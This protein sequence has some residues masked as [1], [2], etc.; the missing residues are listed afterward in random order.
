[1]EGVNQAE[2]KFGWLRAL[3]WPIH[4]HEMKKLVPMLL[5][6]FFITFNYNVL[7]T[8]KDTL[9]VNAKQS[10]A[11]VIPF[12]KFWFMFPGS[13]LMAYLY[14]RLSNRVSR[15]WVFYI[16]AGGF[17]TYFALFAL[18][19]Y[20]NRDLLHPHAFADTMQAAGVRIRALAQPSTARC[21]L[22][23]PHRSVSRCGWKTAQ[24][25]PIM[26]ASH[27]PPRHAARRPP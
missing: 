17:I 27:E 9:V 25:A 18:A 11:E 26:T 15:E 24:P 5:L 14:T 16:I 23:S 10:G 2:S 3:I 19:L 13:V 4:R 1:M 20:P 22:R 12:I 8:L 21:S 6:F 7:R